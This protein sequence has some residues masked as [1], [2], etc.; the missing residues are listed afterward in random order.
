MAG[1]AAIL[2][3]EVRKEYPARRRLGVRR[4]G[5]GGATQAL[6]GVSLAVAEGE[7][8]GVL[9]PNGAGKTT[10]VKIVSTLLSPTSGRVTVGGHD[11]VAHP[12]RARRV[13]GLVT[14]DERSF[15]WRLSGRHNLEFFS[16]LYRVP[17]KIAADRIEMLLEVLGLMDA[18]GRPFHGY[19]TG[20]KQKMAIARGLL[21]DPRV[22]LYDEPTRALDPLSAQNIRRWIAENRQ[23]SPRTAHL[24][25]TN[26]L[27]EAERLCD[28][29]VIVSHGAIIAQ[30][31]VDEIRRR[32]AQRSFA[33]HRVVCRGFVPDG[34]LRPD[35]ERGIVDV[36]VEAREEDRLTLRVRAAEDSDALSAALGAILAAGG[37]VLRCETERTSFDEVFCGLVEGAAIAAGGAGR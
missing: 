19:S 20:M 36:E 1:A 9:G 34:R 33:V 8:V 4:G 24:L 12:L 31:T 35:P 22:I 37:T 13:M 21:A 18:A 25:A 29:V 30:G 5:G 14:C 26:L 3:E 7:M 10:L 15:Y 23:R 6:R 27:H 32:W 11:V 2:V 16:R 17:P 28:R